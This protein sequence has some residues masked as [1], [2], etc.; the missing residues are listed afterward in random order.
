MKPTRKLEIFV[1]DQKSLW[2]VKVNFL[3]KYKVNMIRIKN[4][5]ANL[6]YFIF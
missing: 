2:K 4:V 1:W 5:C 3:L 6:F